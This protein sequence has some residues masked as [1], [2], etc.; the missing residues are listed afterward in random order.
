MCRKL[1]QHPRYRPNLSSAEHYIYPADCYIRIRR[2]GCQLVTHDGIKSDVLT[3][4]FAQKH[5]GSS[6]RLDTTVERLKEC[7]NCAA[8]LTG[9]RS[10]DCN[11]SEDVLDPVVKLR[12]QELLMLLNLLPLGDIEERDDHAVYLAVYCTI[13]AQTNLEPTVSMTSDFTADGRQIRKH[14][15]RILDRVGIFKLV[16]ELG[17][18]PAF[19]RRRDVEQLGHTMGEP[20][21]A[22]AGVEKESSEISHCHQILQIAVRKRDH[23]KLQ[24]ELFR[25][26][27][28]LFVVG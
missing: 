22:K 25:D 14:S 21:D 12:D 20:L 17:D 11:L 9:R 24:L 23:V 13:R 16:G 6:H 1:V 28:Q 10:D 5:V 3:T 15:P 7:I 19:I 2:V 4:A 27:L 18:R 26:R 8:A